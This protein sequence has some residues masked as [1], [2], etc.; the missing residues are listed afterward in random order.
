MPRNRLVHHVVIGPVRGKEGDDL[1]NVQARPRPNKVSYNLLVVCHLLIPMIVDSASS[2]SRSVGPWPI[3][4]ECLVGSGE[5]SGK[6][7]RYHGRPTRNARGDDLRK[8]IRAG[9]RLGRLGRP[10]KLLRS[11]AAAAAKSV[12]DDA[13]DHPREVWTSSPDR[14]GVSRLASRASP[15]HIREL[16]RHRL[17]G[18]H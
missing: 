11:G 15:P 18:I 6:N 17:R 16:W 3:P 1:F 2:L 10:T 8:T 13:R 9:T 14:D 12:N 7:W 5:L 4:T